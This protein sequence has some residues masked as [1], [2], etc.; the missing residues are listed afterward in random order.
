[1]AG[2]GRNL[3]LLEQMLHATALS[4]ACITNTSKQ[5]GPIEIWVGL[6]TFK[7]KVYAQHSVLICCGM[8]VSTAYVATLRIKQYRYIMIYICM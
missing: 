7:P 4:H 8:Y 2:Y 1:M 6:Q 3:C 5:H